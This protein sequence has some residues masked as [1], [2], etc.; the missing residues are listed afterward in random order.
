M[1]TKLNQSK[2][3]LAIVSAMLLGTA[4]LTAPAYAAGTDE[5]MEV[6][7]SIG[8]ACVIETN[9]LNFGPYDAIVANASIPLKKEVAIS[10]TCTAGS[11]GKIKLS[12]GANASGA[13]RRMVHASDGTKF[14]NYEV[15]GASFGGLK[16]DTATG[17]NYTGSGSKEDLPVYGQVAAAQTSAINGSYSDTLTATITY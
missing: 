11:S 12:D 15:S 17:V 9:E 2:L 10:S 3:K 5:S 4:G 6:K 7:A 1:K 8:L 16:W 13:Q 14:L